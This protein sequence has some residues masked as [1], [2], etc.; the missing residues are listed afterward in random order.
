MD[1]QL[2]AIEMQIAL[3]GNHLRRKC[4]VQLDEIDV[5]E[6]H[7]DI[8]KQLLRRGDRAD[9]HDFRIDAGLGVA[10]DPGHRLQRVLLY[11]GFRRD[12]HR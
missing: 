1:V 8:A 12:E 5:L 10:D 7:A 9:A 4:L 6:R 2:L 3:A 11:S